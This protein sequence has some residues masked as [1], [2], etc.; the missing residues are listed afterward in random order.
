MP[1]GDNGGVTDRIS[2]DD[3]V[4]VAISLL[5]TGGLHA[6]AMR[7]IASELGVQQSALYWHFENKQLLLAAIADRIVE[8]LAP[9]DDDDDWASRVTGLA[10]RLRAQLLLYPDG[11][12]LVA[13]AAA[14][15]LGAQR[16]IQLF[17]NELVRG[18][19]RQ[20][21]ADMAS[22]VMVHFVFGYTTDEQQYNQAARLGAITRDELLNGSFDERFLLGVHLIIGGIAARR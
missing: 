6:L 5:E 7:R 18:G 1:V 2:R 15:R 19:L 11:A 14:F 9:A 21:D 13:T 10:T 12:E 17:T 16:P 3:I 4:R 22:S 8:P 20:E